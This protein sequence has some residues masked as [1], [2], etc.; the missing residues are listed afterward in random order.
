MT[1]N[2]ANYDILIIVTH[3]VDIVSKSAKQNVRWKLRKKS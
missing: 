3:Y 2:Q 1:K